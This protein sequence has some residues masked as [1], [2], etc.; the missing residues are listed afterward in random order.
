MSASIRPDEISGILLKELE[1]FQTQ[2]ETYEVGTVLQVGDGI[3][4]IHGLTNAMAG[5]LV[6]FKEHEG[7]KGLVLNLESDNI[8]VALLGDANA[9]CEGDS[10]VLTGKVASL[11]VG[12]TTLGRVLN[13]V[14][15]PI[16][17]GA[18]IDSDIESQIEIK[19]PGIIERMDV[20]EP[21]ETGIK[22]ID[23]MIPVGRGQRELIIGDR[24]T[25]K[26]TVALD[27]IIN[28]R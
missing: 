27:T 16:D 1:S 22:S 28:Q 4:R 3:A 21:M 2:G 25:G 23:A 13:A 20:C 19:A 10:V 17:G 14:G 24:K 26:T 12:P 5:E 11:K 9:V 7:L 6:E 15:E 18:P 8:G